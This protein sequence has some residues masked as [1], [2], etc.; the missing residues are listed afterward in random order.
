MTAA[1]YPHRDKRSIFLEDVERIACPVQL[2]DASRKER[3]PALCQRHAKGLPQVN[4]DRG[5]LSQA[6]PDKP[7]GSDVDPRETWFG[8]EARQRREAIRLPENVPHPIA[9]PRNRVVG[10]LARDDTQ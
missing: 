10:V 6:D 5:I 3:A 2:P 1:L 9:E 4:L 7:G 8:K